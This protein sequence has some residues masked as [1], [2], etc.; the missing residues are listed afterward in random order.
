MPNWP[1]GTWSSAPAGTVTEPTTSHVLAPA[2]TVVHVAVQVSVAVVVVVTMLVSVPLAGSAK[3]A[4]GVVATPVRVKFENEPETRPSSVASNTPCVVAPSSVQ[5][6][7][8][9]CGL[10]PSD[11]RSTLG[12]KLRIS[13]SETRIDCSSVFRPSSVALI[14]I[15]GV[16]GELMSMRCPAAMRPATLNWVGRTTMAPLRSHAAAFTLSSIT[17]Y[18]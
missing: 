14:P 10:L 4:T 13:T 8:P 15:T 16:N 1:A 6:V 5:T 11:G 12:S 17:A 18:T 2:A 9:L 3:L 7:R